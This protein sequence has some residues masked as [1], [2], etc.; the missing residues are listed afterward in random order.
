M[1]LQGR[2]RYFGGKVIGVGWNFCGFEKRVY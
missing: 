2:L 1:V